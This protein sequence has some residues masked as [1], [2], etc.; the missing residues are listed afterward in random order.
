MKTLL[1]DFYNFAFAFS[2]WVGSIFN[3]VDN[4]YEKLSGSIVLLI[5]TLDLNVTKF[6][7]ILF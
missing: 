5:E 6:K 4:Y 1:P 2:D 7:N 3:R